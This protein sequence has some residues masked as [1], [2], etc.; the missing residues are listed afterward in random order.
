[1]GDLLGMSLTTDNVQPSSLPNNWRIG[2]LTI[3]GIFMGLS[4][5]VLCAGVLAVGHFGL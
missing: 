4:E 1:V 2:K 5:L 3:A